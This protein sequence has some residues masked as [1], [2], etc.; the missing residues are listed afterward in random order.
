MSE[1]KK[2]EI[3]DCRNCAAKKT[4]HYKETHDD[5]LEGL[6]CRAHQSQR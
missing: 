5:L 1:K 3:R 2:V 4:C 6:K